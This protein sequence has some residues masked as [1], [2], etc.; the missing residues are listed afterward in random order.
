MREDLGSTCF[1]AVWAKDVRRQGLLPGSLAELERW[2]RACAARGGGP[3]LFACDEAGRVHRRRLPGL[4]SARRL[5]TS[6]AARIPTCARAGRAALLMWESIGRARGVT[7]VLRLRGLDAEAGRALLPGLRQSPP[8][9]LSAVRSPSGRPGAA[10]PRAK[11][12][13]GFAP[14]RRP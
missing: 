12:C 9:P 3:M 5:P 11:A 10:S 6:S 1:H 14:R 2:T 4:G 13:A 7:D 8:D